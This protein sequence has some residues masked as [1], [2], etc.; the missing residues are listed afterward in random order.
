M[1]SNIDFIKYYIFITHVLLPTN[2]L[3]ISLLYPFPFPL[4]IPTPSCQPDLHIIFTFRLAMMMKSVHVIFVV[5]V[6]GWSLKIGH[7]L[8]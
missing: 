7:H 5:A 8:Y 2:L 4:K 1:T 6:S 3:I